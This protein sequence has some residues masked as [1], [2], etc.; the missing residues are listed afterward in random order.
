M[1]VSRAC[2]EYCNALRISCKTR[3]TFQLSISEHLESRQEGLQTSYKLLC[4][5]ALLLLFPRKL[6]RLDK[7]YQRQGQDKKGKNIRLPHATA[8]AVFYLFLHAFWQAYFY[9]LEKFDYEMPT[10]QLQIRFTHAWN[11]KAL[12]LT[13]L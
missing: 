6:M 1:E 12:F 11:D 7:G 5:L 4:G 3:Q 13:K 9:P 8:L 10:F 2:S